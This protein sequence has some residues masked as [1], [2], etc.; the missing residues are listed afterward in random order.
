MRSPRKER[1]PTLLDFAV[2]LS[3]TL[4]FAPDLLDGSLQIATLQFFIAMTVINLLDL[5]LPHGDSV[6]IDSALIVAA[7]Y[8]VGPAEAMLAA[9]SA[10]LLARTLSGGWRRPRAVGGGVAKRLVGLT[11]AA[12]VWTGLSRQVAEGSMGTYLALLLAG[13]VFVLAELAYGQIA[14]AYLRSD[15][16][17]RMARSNLV[18]QG[19]LL[20]SAV[21]VAIL[22]VMIYED[23]TTWGL[24][25]MTF[26]LLAMRQSFALLLDVRGA[27]HS[28]VE[29][30]V[31]AMEAQRP[32]E[33]GVGE[34][35]AMLAR[36]A[37]A[38]Y[39]WYGSPV[40]TLGY[41]ALLHYF[42]LSFVTIDETEGQERPT[43]LAEVKF[44][45]LVAPIVTLLGCADVAHP[46]ERELVSAY[47]V[48][49]C[50]AALELSNGAEL[51]ARLRP[52][53]STETASRADRAVA[54]ALEKALLS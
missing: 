10:W 21:S 5:V 38:E 35:V 12:P 39:G 49:K 9:A 45:E 7:L 37:G 44:F 41:A 23:M 8:L 13:T 11:F 42:G 6:D 47:I 20:A 4:L 29:A 2:I 54:R 50:L 33:S 24:T 22:T 1:V 30:L 36:R 18:L 3:A 34:R 31:G 17:L 16:P 53:V 43:P 26:L 14:V 25:L 48:A 27:Y 46:R 32:G 40:E 52:L 51:V 15:S 19:P 28:T